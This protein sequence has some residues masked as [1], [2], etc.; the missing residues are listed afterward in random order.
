[1][2]GVSVSH[3]CLHPL[4]LAH[5]SAPCY[6]SHKSRLFQRFPFSDPTSW[7]GK[8]RIYLSWATETERCCQAVLQYTVAQGTA[9]NHSQK[10]RVHPHFMSHTFIPQGLTY[11]RKLTV[12][13]HAYIQNQEV[14]L[15]QKKP[16][17]LF[18]MDLG[19]YSSLK[20]F[21]VC[22][23][24]TAVR[25]EGLFM[26]KQY[27]LNQGIAKPSLILKVLAHICQ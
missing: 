11:C 21:A 7:V 6:F 2:V 20:R 18:V 25:D 27:M 15:K 1:M 17:G 22:I 24:G 16:P 10:T 3:R 13:Y 14:Y 9:L 23:A 12:G 8:S 5:I 19:K 26:K 4:H